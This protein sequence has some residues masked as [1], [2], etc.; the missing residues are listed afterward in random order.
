MR[1]V[2]SHEATS[3]HYKTWKVKMRLKGVAG[4][5]NKSFLLK[6]SHI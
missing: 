4:S 3:D 2:F 1:V 6:I 5:A